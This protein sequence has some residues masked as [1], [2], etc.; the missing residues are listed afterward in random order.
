MFRPMPLLV[1]AALALVA[2]GGYDILRGAPESVAPVPSAAAPAPLELT[3]SHTPLGEVVTSAGAALYRS[4]KD[5]AKPAKSNCVGQCATTWP[6]VLASDGAPQLAGVEPG[7]VGIAVRPDGTRQVTLAGWPLYRYAGDT[8]PGELK[9]EG[10]GG[11]WHVVAPNG[12]P[13]V[14]VSKA[15]KQAADPAEPPAAATDSTGTG[16]AAA[17]KPAQPAPP[18]PAPAPAP[19]DEGSSGSYGY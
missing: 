4:N 9:G 13:A 16:G 11:V 5:T 19:S 7:A 6:P 12:K 8:A 17:P 15:A 1:A 3:A 18:A 10:I 2:L 14:A